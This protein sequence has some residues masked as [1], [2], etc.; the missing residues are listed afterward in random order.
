M[1]DNISKLNEYGFKD[2]QDG[3]GNGKNPTR[4]RFSLESTF[5]V[6]DKVFEPEGRG[7]SGNTSISAHW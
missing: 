6:T 4:L 7:L 3:L 1:I 2:G 5:T